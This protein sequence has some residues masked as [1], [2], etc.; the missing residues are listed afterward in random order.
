MAVDQMELDPNERAD[1]ARA[2]LAQSLLAYATGVALEEV[3]GRTR[4]AAEASFARQVAMYLAHVAGGMSLA[5][6]ANAFRRDRSTVAHACHVVED[7]RD[8]LAF[9]VWIEALEEAMRAAPEPFGGQAALQ[10]RRVAA[11]GRR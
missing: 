1:R 9:D 5:R 10:S 7:R 6:V 11:R 4:G 3:R 8:E 2:G